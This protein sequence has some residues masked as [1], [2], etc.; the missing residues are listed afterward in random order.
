MFVLPFKRLISRPK[1]PGEKAVQHMT[2]E[3]QEITN[4]KRRS[5]WFWK[6]KLEV[7]LFYHSRK[8]QI[9]VA[10]LILTNFF[11]EC[12]QRQIDP[13]SAAFR[14]GVVWEAFEGFFS[15]C[16][17]LELLV[18]M[19][20][21]WMR[22]FFRHVWNWFD[23]FVVLIGIL[24]ITKCPLPG[25]LKLVRMFRAFRVFR[26]FAR[27]ESLMKILVSLERA[28][29][30]VLNAFV[31]M[32]LVVCIYAVLA[33]D[34]FGKLH[35]DCMAM[36]AN[37]TAVTARGLC[38]GEDYYG[39]FFRSLYTLFQVLTGE[40]WSEA[41]VRPVL[42]MSTGFDVF[43]HSVFFITFVIINGMVLL[44]VVVAVLLDGM[45]PLPAEPATDENTATSTPEEGLAALREDVAEVKQMLTAMSADLRQLLA[46]VQN[47]ADGAC[48]ARP[49]AI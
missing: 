22:P 16:F 10:G 39:N 45:S 29:P 32:L 4:D 23:M 19:Y 43:V 21:S 14:W 26:L 20:G 30:G 17:L 46:A 42:H 2:S 11:V 28:L 49:C 7:Y 40:S 9:F 27:I 6:Y 48:L 34:L 24:S 35:S 44:N 3:L 41:A 5:R 37:P 33:V 1:L 13:D 36:P 12:T 31:I 18:N 25:P 8:M 15:V 47:D 38:Y